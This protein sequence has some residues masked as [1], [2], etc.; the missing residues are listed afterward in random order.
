MDYAW[1]LTWNDEIELSFLKMLRSSWNFFNDLKR[2][3]SSTM[4]FVVFP[5]IAKIDNFKRLKSFFCQFAWFSDYLFMCL[6]L[7]N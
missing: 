3:Y 2:K 5:I 1:K 4:I 7:D 6:Y